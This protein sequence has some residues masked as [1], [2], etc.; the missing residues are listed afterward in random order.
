MQK[1]FANLW[2]AVRFLPFLLYI[3]G[4]TPDE[5]AMMAAQWITFKKAIRLNKADDREW[6]TTELKELCDVLEV[7]AAVREAAPKRTF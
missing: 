3:P 2:I 7:P 1:N 6:Y 5:T 4:M